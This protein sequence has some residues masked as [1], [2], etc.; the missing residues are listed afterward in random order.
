MD[1]RQIV[2]TAAA[3]T[4]VFIA[5]VLTVDAQPV[6][7]P[8]SIP[9]PAPA[10][11]PSPLPTPVTPPENPLVTTRV[12]SEFDAWQRGH[13]NRSTY[14]PMAGG[15]YINALIGQVQPDLQAIGAVQTVSYETVSVLYGDFVYLYDVTG[16]TGEVSVLCALDDRGKVDDI[17]FTPRIFVAPSPSPTPLPASPSPVPTPMPATSPST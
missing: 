7:P 15:T 8:A 16:T 2:R 5:T 10:N 14:T 9:T 6:T 17:V 1:M 11:N 4:L 13:I 12:R 3:T